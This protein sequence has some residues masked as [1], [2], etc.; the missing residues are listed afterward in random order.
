MGNRI[1]YDHWTDSRL[2]YLASLQAP[3]EAT[4]A[5]YTPVRWFLS[6]VLCLLFAYLV[7]WALAP[8]E[9][10]ADFELT[11]GADGQMAD[12][13]TATV[14]RLEP[15]APDILICRAGEGIPPSATVVCPCRDY[16]P[17]PLQCLLLVRTFQDETW[18]ACAY[19]DRA[20]PVHPVVGPWRKV[21]P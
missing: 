8:L 17:H 14:L 7:L 3:E 9:A 4:P 20:H 15:G 13:V 21:T 18:A 2:V 12:T 10:R 6:W 11:C 5:P 16:H 1:R 19:L